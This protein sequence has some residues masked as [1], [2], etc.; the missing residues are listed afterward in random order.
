M[1]DLI[2]TLIFTYLFIDLFQFIILDSFCYNLP[3]F[4]SVEVFIFGKIGIENRLEQSQ[5]I[6]FINFLLA[7]EL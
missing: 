3:V 5:V 6:D 2:I 7:V 4:V 1:K